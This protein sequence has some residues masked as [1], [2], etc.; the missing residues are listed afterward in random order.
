MN[1]QILIEQIAQHGLASTS[2]D[3]MVA[4]A[5]AYWHEGFIPDFDR[6]THLPKSQL[7]VI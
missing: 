1:P 2:A 3:D 4:L 5:C 7:P 6:S